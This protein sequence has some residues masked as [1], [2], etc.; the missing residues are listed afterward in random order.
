MLSEGF[1]FAYPCQ[2]KTPEFPTDSRQSKPSEYVDRDISD[3]FD[4]SRIPPRVAFKLLPARA[5]IEREIT[6]LL[7]A[8]PNEPPA[9]M[10]IS[11][12]DSRYAAI[13]RVQSTLVVKR[14]GIDSY[15]GRLCARGDTAPLQNTAFVSSPTAHRCAVKLICAIAS[16]LQWVIRAIDISQAFL[17]SSNLNERDRVIVIPP[18]MIHLPWTGKLPPM[19]TDLSRL[20]HQRGFLL[21]RPLYGGRDAPMRWF[22]PSS[23]RLREHGFT[24]MKTDVCIYSKRDSHGNLAGLLVAHVDDLLFCGTATFR[25]E[26]LRVIHTFRTGDVETLTKTSPIISTGMMI[27]L[28]SPTSILLPQQMYADELPVMD[29]T[30]YVSKSGIT[31]AAGLKST[32][33]QGL[34]AL[35]WL[36]QTRPD[37]GF[38]VTQMAT[39]IVE[40]CES[41]E[42]AIQLARLYNK[43]VKF[44]KNHRRKIRYARFPT[45]AN[46]SP[47][48]P[49]DLLNW[50]LFVFTDAGFGTLVKNHSVESRV[51]VL[52]DVIA[53]DGILTCHGLLLDHRCA[54]I[55]RVCRST[56]SAETHAAVSA[57]DVAL[58]FQVLLIEIF[59]HRFEYQ[60]LT[61]PTF[62]P[63]QNPF[64]ESPSDAEVKKE[65]SGN[66]IH[67]LISASSH[68]AHPMM[69]DVS[70]EFLATCHC[71]K[72]SR[73][74][75]T[76]STDML[77]S[78]QNEKFRTVLFQ[79]H[80][81]LFHPLILTDCCSLYS[82]IL[83]L[84]PKTVER[85]TR[86]TLA[87]LRD[88]LDIIAFSY[89]DAT[90]NIGDVG[91]RHAGNLGIL[92]QFL[93][94]GR[95][96]LS[97][98]GRKKRQEMS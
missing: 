19:H 32:F 56:L 15:K 9:M 93:K 64:R 87:F 57:V 45:G 65:A 44:V 62:F 85:C 59:T 48:T 53:R 16:Q 27:E 42:K 74:L 78:S 24:Q 55:H 43:M 22:I 40:A 21:L 68:S 46:E 86:I 97:F 2:S 6:D 41:P 35:I 77:D 51:V 25:K 71:C 8:K 11:L 38:A 80:A 61:P 70:E 1:H 10:E 91:T 79:K 66:L 63:L 94:T 12:N 3:G 37:I 20:K 36:H 14:K 67:A 84:Q 75:S 88:A 69:T 96:T 92:D 31:N 89:I 30:E 54:K 28:D 17:Q 13:P 34:G 73:K 72:V 39:Q 83:R 47:R 4:P 33:K 5:A 76:L 52:G 23:K 82:A 18:P 7:L 95:F 81:I 98:A 60:R 49:N 29:V 90:V 58:W 26:A 50:E